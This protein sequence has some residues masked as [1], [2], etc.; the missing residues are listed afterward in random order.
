VTV[1]VCRA[2]E[3]P[4]TCGVG[5]PNVLTV[6]QAVATGK[7]LAQGRTDASGLVRLPASIAPGTALRLRLPALGAQQDLDAG[8]D[9]VPVIIAGEA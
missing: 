6:L 1:Q 5:L 3:T 4:S 9:Q 2:G 8:A 7:V